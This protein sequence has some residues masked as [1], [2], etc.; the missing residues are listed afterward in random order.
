MTT[1]LQDLRYGLRMLAKNPG[2]TAVA[3]LTLALGIGATTAI[4]TVVN[5]ELLRPL[6]YPHPEELVYVQE[7]LDKFGATPFAANHEFVAWR[8]QSRTLSPVAAYMNTWFNLTGEGEPERVTCGLATTSFF[9]LLGVRPVAGRLFL[10]EEDRPGGPPVVILSEALWKR[11][12]GGDPSVVGK[13]VTLDGETYTVVG[14]L[15]A[16]F[17]IPDAFKTD[18]ALWV[19]LAESDTGAGLFRLVRVIGRL[20][21]GNEPGSV[22]EQS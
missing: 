22:R 16:S 3:V 18:Y 14:V 17:V 12:Y 20:K 13:G 8:N 7:I 1:L 19:P 11:R 21:T 6:P 15:P 4:F 5:A 2:F 10:P 9:S